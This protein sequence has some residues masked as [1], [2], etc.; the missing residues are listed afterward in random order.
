M[1]LFALFVL[2]AGDENH[3]CRS[4]VIGMRSYPPQYPRIVRSLSY[5]RS[6]APLNNLTVGIRGSTNEAA[7]QNRLS[8]RGL[9]NKKTRDVIRRQ[10]IHKTLELS[11]VIL[12]QFHVA[13]HMSPEWALH[14][15]A[16]DISNYRTI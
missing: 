6:S 15:E 8:K 2:F 4:I 14:A 1:A 5:P 10:A 16:D 3:S 11:D 12:R 13:T 7:W 9:D